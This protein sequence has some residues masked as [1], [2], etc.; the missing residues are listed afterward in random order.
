M[1][2]IRTESGN[3]INASYKSGM[4]EKWRKKSKTD[5]NVIND[6]DDNDD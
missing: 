3:L 2:K 4:Y 5:R 1:K 6:N